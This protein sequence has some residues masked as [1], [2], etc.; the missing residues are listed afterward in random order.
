MQ[1]EDPEY[2]P[3]PLPQVGNPQL[4]AGE[5][6]DEPHREPLHHAEVFEHPG[7]DDPEDRRAEC[8]TGDEV[9]DQ[10]GHAEIVGHLPE[11]VGRQEEDAEQEQGPG[12]NDAFGRDAKRL[13]KDRAT[14]QQ[15]EHDEPANHVVGTGRSRS[16]LNQAAASL[17]ATI[18]NRST[19]SRVAVST[20]AGA[21]SE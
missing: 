3:I 4:G 9:P 20:V 17:L 7:G 13:E 6:P 2:L 5:K 19:D 10:P 15:G 8:Q 16:E 18:S 14:D 12:G 21:R 1:H 11:G